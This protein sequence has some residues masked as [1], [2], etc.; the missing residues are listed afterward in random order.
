MSNLACKNIGVECNFMTND[1]KVEKVIQEFREHVILEHS[2]DYPE[3]ILKKFIMY[4]K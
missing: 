4:K 3:G 2:I 1:E